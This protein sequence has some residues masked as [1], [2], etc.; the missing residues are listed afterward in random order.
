MLPVNSDA[1]H[2]TPWSIKQKAAAALAVFC[3][4]NPFTAAV[5]VALSSSRVTTGTFVNATCPPLRL[6]PAVIQEYLERGT[7]SHFKSVAQGQ[8]ESELFDSYDDREMVSQLLSEAKDDVRRVAEEAH[9]AE[10]A[11]ALHQARQGVNENSMED[12]KLRVLEADACSDAALVAETAHEKLQ[13][14]ARGLKELDYQNRHFYCRDSYTCNV[15]STLW[16]IASK[17]FLQKSDRDPH[18]HDSIIRR[19]HRAI[20]NN[21]YYAAESLRIAAFCTKHSDCLGAEEMALADYEEAIRI[22][23]NINTMDLSL[24][25]RGKLQDEILNTAILAYR[26]ERLPENQNALR[27]RVVAESM[28]AADI[29]AEDP[30]DTYFTIQRALRLED[31][32]LFSVNTTER[33]DRLQQAVMLVEDAWSRDPEGCLN[34]PGFDRADYRY[35]WYERPFKLE[36]TLLGRLK[37]KLEATVNAIARENSIFSPFYY[38]WQCVRESISRDPL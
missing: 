6:S 24:E 26:T 18:S 22:M 35:G 36:N 37:N 15:A 34:V 27:E 9:P 10:R 11:I 3:I 2:T 7:A 13:W 23:R 33:V 38:A 32:A 1:G 19:E 28:T 29:Y 20:D 14:V 4:I 12:R 25:D 5:G 30:T 17:A 31:A 21:A 8:L 16:L